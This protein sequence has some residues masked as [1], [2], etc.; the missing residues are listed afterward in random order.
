MAED[1]LLVI[2]ESQIKE[3]LEQYVMRDEEGNFL[4]DDE[5][6][7]TKVINQIRQQAREIDRDKLIDIIDDAIEGWL[8][9]GKDIA[10]AIIKEIGG[11]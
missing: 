11:E 3:V 7:A 5:K 8:D 4:F 6:L 9:E 1:K 10:T 2:R